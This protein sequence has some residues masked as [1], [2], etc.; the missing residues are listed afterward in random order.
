MRIVRLGVAF[1][2]LAGLASGA[3]LAASPPPDTLAQRV[4][5]CTACHDDSGRRG[6]D[7]YY[8]RI[9][10]KPAGYLY[11]QLLNFKEGRRFYALMT[12]QVEH[13][14]DAYLR[15]IAEHFA[16]LE[17]PYAAPLAASIRRESLERGRALVHEG[18]AQGKLPA[19]TEC[20]GKRLTGVAPA[21]PALVGLPRDYLIAQ[22]NAWRSGVRRAHE[23]DCMA[24]VA[25]RLAPED[26][27]AIASWLA[28][29]PVLGRAEPRASGTPPIACGSVT[30]AAAK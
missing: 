12:Y 26:V 6:T 5:A 14:P 28:T 30:D 13:L 22:L 19:C 20:H 24:E 9:A 16:A 27:A 1:L 15:E 11:H 23:P 17:R 8:P 10:G 3:S 2:S 21:I 4:A 29:Q 7:A 25:R 18:D